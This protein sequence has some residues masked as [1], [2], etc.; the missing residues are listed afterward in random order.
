MAILGT[1]RGLALATH[2]G[3]AL[4]VTGLTALLAAGDRT[5]LATGSLV[6]AA[7]FT[8]QLGI[9]WSNDVLDEARDRAAGRSDKPV[10]AGAVSAATVRVAIAGS[11]VVCVVL[12]LACGLMSGLVHLL[13]GVASGWAYNL[14]FKRMVLSP[15]PY[16]VAFGVLPAVVTLAGADPSWPPV[17]VMAAGALLGVG[18]HL[19]NALP[20]LADDRAAGVLGLPQ[21]LGDRVVRV[22]APVILLTASVVCV[23]GRG[24]SPAGWALLAI[25]VVLA[26][27][28]AVGRGRWPFAAAI[29]IALADVVLLVGA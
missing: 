2:P 11:L 27:A 9:G 13:L 29:G 10:A 18:A 16:A 12:S 14:W 17:W 1:A 21:R 20:D 8:G 4:A 24:P 15:L 22:L 7:V 19:L 25:C 6:T 3:P 5:G 26:A 28:A 23:L